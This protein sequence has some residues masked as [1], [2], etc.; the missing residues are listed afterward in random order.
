MD[1]LT[2]FGGNPVVGALA[3]REATPGNVCRPEFSGSVSSTGKRRWV[4]PLVSRNVGTELPQTWYS[5]G[6]NEYVLVELSEA[7]SY[8]LANLE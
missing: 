2:T 3:V 5:Y 8:N 7:M 1:G 4:Q 6:G